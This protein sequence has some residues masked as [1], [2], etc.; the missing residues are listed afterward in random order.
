MN[1]PHSQGIQVRYCTRELSA[2]EGRRYRHAEGVL[3]FMPG[4]L[5]KVIEVPIMDEEGWRP[6]ERFTVDL[7]DPEVVTGPAIAGV[8]LRLATHVTTVTV[9][10]D[11][12]PGTMCFEAEELYANHG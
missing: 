1:R 7:F 8:N 6:H 4:Q 5:E 11:D 9:V 3:N 2:R 10:N 12:M